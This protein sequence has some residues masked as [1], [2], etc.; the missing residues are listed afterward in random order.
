MDFEILGIWTWA[1]VDMMTQS[2]PMSLSVVRVCMHVQIAEHQKGKLAKSDT[3]KTKTQ[4]LTC[5][6][7]SDRDFDRFEKE[8]VFW[9]VA[10]SL[11]HCLSCHLSCN[12]DVSADIYWTLCATLSLLCTTPCLKNV[13]PLDCY[14]FETWECILIFFGRNVTD[15]VCNQKTLLCL[16]K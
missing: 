1:S 14:N 13:P 15:R 11:L 16:L 5:S 2:K 6:V 9:H 3:G 10:C 4:E 7:F 8:Y 12:I